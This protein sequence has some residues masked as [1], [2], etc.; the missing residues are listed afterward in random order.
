[1]SDYIDNFTTY[2]LHA[3]ITS[4]LHQVSLFITGLQD[5]LRMAI[6]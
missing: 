5:A 6:I 4:E 3:G 1:V 2:V